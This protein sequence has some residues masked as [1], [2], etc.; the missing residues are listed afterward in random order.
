MIE[1]VSRIQRAVPQ[2]FVNRSMQLIA[3]RSRHDAYLRAGTFS[4]SGAVGVLHHRKFPH[5]VYTQ[6]LPTRASRCV[7]DFRGARKFHAVQKE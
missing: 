2:K 5:G 3:A 1:E 4:V 7:V 6:K